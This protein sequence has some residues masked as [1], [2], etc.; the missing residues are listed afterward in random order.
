MPFVESKWQ[1]SSST[2]TALSNLKSDL[3]GWN[4]EVFGNLQYRKD[5]LFRRI[6]GVERVLA[7]GAPTRLLKLQNR[8]KGE[9][10]DVLQQ[11]EVLW[12]QK[13]R[14]KWIEGGDRNTTFFHASAIVRRRRNHISALRD[15]ENNWVTEKQNL[16]D[17]PFSDDG[18]WSGVKGMGAHKAPGIDGFQPVFY[19][20]CWAVVRESVTSFIRNFFSSGVLLTAANETILHLIGKVASPKMVS[21]F[22]PISLCNVIYKMI[23]KILSKRLQPLM[24]KLVSPMQSSF[25]P[26]RSKLCSASSY[27]WRSILWALENGVYKGL[28]WSISDGRRVRF[29]ED[30]WLEGGPLIHAASRSVDA[31]ILNRPVKD[32]WDV[33]SGWK[34]N[35]ISNFLPGMTLMRL[36]AIV[37]QPGGSAGFAN[38][39]LLK[40][41]YVYG[42]F[43]L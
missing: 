3:Q 13:S 11:E 34:W 12:F 43:G 1:R 26:G 42:E 10:E 6:E 16:E 25:I 21:Q 18:K 15:E 40:R 9:L 30:S 22:R 33:G 39:E 37:V 20:K 19:Q 27:V 7:N 5:K 36:C 17:M 35:I 29:W 24:D 14:E 28:K 8:L 38:L 2:I 4:R 23:T 32:F 31:S 41:W